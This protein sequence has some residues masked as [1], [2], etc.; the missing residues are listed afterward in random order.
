MLQNHFFGL[1]NVHC[2]EFFA[3]SMRSARDHPYKLTKVSRSTSCRSQFLVSVH[4]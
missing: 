2:D 4:S 1:I 3:F